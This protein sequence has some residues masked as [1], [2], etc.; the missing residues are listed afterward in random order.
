MKYQNRELAQKLKINLAKW[1]RW[2]REFLPPDPVAGM[3]CGF[4]REYNPEEAFSVYFGGH[5]VSILKFSIPDAKVIVNDLLPWF[6]KRGF[7]PLKD[8]KDKRKEDP[9]EYWA[10]DIKQGEHGFMYEAKGN[11]FFDSLDRNTEKVFQVTYIIERILP[12]GEKGTYF[13]PG[14][15]ALQITHM[16][17]DF[18]TGM[19]LDNEPPSG[20][21]KTLFRKSK[22]CQKK[23]DAYRRAFHN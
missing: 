6:Y 5:L 12:P 1:K 8:W 7:F 9:V 10:M 13:L 2:S 19:G 3:Q 22:E 11:I 4:A 16:V 15:H 21:S 18:T 17:H 14:E 20:L 23:Q